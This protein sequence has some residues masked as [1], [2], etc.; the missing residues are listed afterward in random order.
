LH[1]V[2]RAFP[3]SVFALLCPFHKI[4]RAG[5]LRLL[6]PPVTLFRS[7]LSPVPQAFAE[8]IYLGFFPSLV[9]SPLP[10]M[11]IALV[12][13]GCNVDLVHPP[14][15]RPLEYVNVAKLSLPS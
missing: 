3:L 13:P 11:V 9:S 7:I 8:L 1:L 12:V 2:Y 15:F 6:L 14:V 10:P 5:D 4:E